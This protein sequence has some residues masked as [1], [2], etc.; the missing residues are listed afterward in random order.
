MLGFAIA[1]LIVAIYHVGYGVLL[2]SALM[3]ALVFLWWWNVAWLTIG[4]LF[5]TALGSGL[6]GGAAAGLSPLSPRLGTATLRPALF[7]QNAFARTFEIIGSRNEI[8]AHA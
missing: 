2:T 1:A 4:I 6:G 7:F 5:V 8:A 3:T